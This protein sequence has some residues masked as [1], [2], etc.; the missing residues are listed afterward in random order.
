MNELPNEINIII[1][2]FIGNN[3]IVTKY[4]YDYLKNARESFIERPL[5]LYYRVARWKYPSRWGGE[6]NHIINTLKTPMRLKMR[7]S[8]IRCVDISNIPIGRLK[9]NGII[10]PSRFLERKIIPRPMQIYD[11]NN[12]YINTRGSTWSIYTIYSEN[13][14]RCKNYINVWPHIG[15]VN[16]WIIPRNMN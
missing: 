3:F 10:Y 12:I 2:S 6:S 5:T 13:I 7:V 4:F 16:S 14:E 9:E 15:N 8:K 11:N 1:Y